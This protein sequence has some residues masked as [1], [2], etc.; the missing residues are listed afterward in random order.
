MSAKDTPTQNEFDFQAETQ[1]VLSLVINSLY[2]HSEVFLREL[3]SNASDALDKARIT[4]LSD[5]NAREQEGEPAIELELDKDSKTLTLR[6]NGVG[7]TR[8]E[9]IDNL[10]T[11]ARSGTTEFLEK[12]ADELQESRGNNEVQIAKFTRWQQCL[13]DI[14]GTEETLMR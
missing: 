1:R 13:T 14:I 12:L 10:G 8:T 5:K 11:I 7:M 3:I 9:V 4:A 6:D 2:T